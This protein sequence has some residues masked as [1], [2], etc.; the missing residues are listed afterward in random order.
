MA[1]TSKFTIKSFLEILVFHWFQLKNVCLIKI[2][3]HLLEE[4]ERKDERCLTNCSCET[5]TVVWISSATKMEVLKSENV[6]ENLNETKI[7]FDETFNDWTLALK[8][9]GS[10]TFILK[11]EIK[12]NLNQVWILSIHSSTHSPK[13]FF[14][15]SDI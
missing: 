15:K 6:T 13:T 1:A 12:Q 2:V 14:I 8:S 10:K 5:I 4:I 7:D 3:L 9:R 11:L